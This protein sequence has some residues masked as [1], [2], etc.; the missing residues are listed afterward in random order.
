M[1]KYVRLNGNQVQEQQAISTSAGVADANKIVET[2]ADGKLSQTLMPTGV[3]PETKSIQ[4]SENLSAGELVNVHDVAGSPRVRRADASNGRIAGGF[5]LAGV[6]S[7][8]NATVFF[9]GAITG[10]SGLTSGSKMF[11]SAT[12]PGAATATAPTTAGQYYQQIG[13]AADATTIS[14]SPQMDILLA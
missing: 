5:V 9:E 3:G 1:A 8:S 7:G 4:A 12:T 2:G 11:L 10:L 14:F 6:A 13:I